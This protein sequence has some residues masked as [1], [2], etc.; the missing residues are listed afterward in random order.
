MQR[1]L[2]LT[3]ALCCLDVEGE[4]IQCLLQLNSGRLLPCLGL[5]HLRSAPWRLTQVVWQAATVSK[6]FCPALEGICL[7]NLLGPCLQRCLLQC[8]LG[9]APSAACLPVTQAVKF[10]EQAKEGQNQLHLIQNKRTHH[11]QDKAWTNYPALPCR[12]LT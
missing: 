12:S 8:K 10:V 3:R 1:L 6:Q 4:Y 5:M 9:H 7:H 11:Q 2:Q